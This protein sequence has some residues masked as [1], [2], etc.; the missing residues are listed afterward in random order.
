MRSGIRPRVSALWT[1]SCEPIL[2]RD[3]RLQ[4]P[5]PHVSTAAPLFGMPNDFSVRCT[6]LCCTRSGPKSASFRRDLRS[7]PRT[8]RKVERTENLSVGC[9]RARKPL[10][11]ATAADKPLLVQM[12]PQSSHRIV[13]IPTDEARLAAA[14]EAGP[15]PSRAM[16]SGTANHRQRSLNRKQSRRF[17]ETRGPSSLQGFTLPGL[18]LP[19]AHRHK[20]L[21]Q[22]LLSKAGKQRFELTGDEGGHAED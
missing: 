22:P 1:H 4:A 20:P 21:E 7:E 6:T 14:S 5:N 18:A 9:I 16:S 11:Q 17:A 15:T 8:T 13:H 10:L 19:K 12:T 3:A 2:A